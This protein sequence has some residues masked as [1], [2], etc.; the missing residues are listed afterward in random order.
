MK[1][2]EQIGGAGSWFEAASGRDTVEL[3][4]VDEAVEALLKVVSRARRHGPLSLRD[5]VLDAARNLLESG[6]AAQSQ[7]LM[8]CCA[9]LE[10]GYQ[11]V[12]CI[13][14]DDMLGGSQA[15]PRDLAEWVGALDEAVDQLTRWLHPDIDARPADLWEDT[16]D[17]AMRAVGFDATELTALNIGLGCGDGPAASVVLPLEG[18]L[19]DFQDASQGAD[20]VVFVRLRAKDPKHHQ[21]LSSIRRLR[22]H[23]TAA[24]VVFTDSRSTRLWG[25]A[26]QAGAQT[27]CAW[28]PNED[29]WV[30]LRRA[31]MRPRGASGSTKAPVAVIGSNEVGCA[32]LVEW[33]RAHRILARAVPSG[34]DVVSE[35]GRAVP[36]V[37]LVMGSVVGMSTPDLCRLL[38]ADIAL[39]RPPVVVID[40]IIDG[41]SRIRLLASGA[42]SL[43]SRSQTGGELLAH[44]DSVLDLGRPDT[45]FYRETATLQELIE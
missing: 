18:P 29:T 9:S 19:E 20:G 31:L 8:D 44:L 33:L 42:E 15:D 37:V 40:E 25:A 21:I 10:A 12:A 26:V 17:C 30:D 23:A 39:G 32:R 7:Y 3:G 35:L 16:S 2:T 6:S 22:T 27:T 43:W 24:V 1:P 11:A 13:S 41:P 4:T 34:R 14:I 5:S 28:P 38:H 36:R 45:H